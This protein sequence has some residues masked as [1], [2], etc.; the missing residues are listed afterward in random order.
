MNWSYVVNAIPR[1]ID[2]A[3][4]TL[5]LSFWGILLSLI[6]GLL[7]AVVTAY[8]VKPFYGL[9]RGYIEL[10]RN[11]PLLIQLFFL[12]YGLPKIGIKWDGFTC[13]IIALVFLGASYMAVSIPAIGANV[14]F[15]IKETSVISAVAVAELMFVTKDIIGMDYKTNEA[16]FL[17]FASYL[18]ILLPISLLARHFENK[19]RSAKYGV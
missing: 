16:L 1:F 8:Q 9:A 10:S 15:L 18:V 4:I 3:I 17:L 13:G 7:I 2:A 6:F 11:T 14:L 5:Q 19:A 12:Y